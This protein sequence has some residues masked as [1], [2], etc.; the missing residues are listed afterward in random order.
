LA[1][2]GKSGK[3]GF[4]EK[5]AKIEKSGFLEI[6]KIRKKPENRQKPK[7]RDFGGFWKLAKNQKYPNGAEFEYKGKNVKVLDY[8]KS[9]SCYKIMYKDKE[10]LVSEKLLD[11]LT[12][13]KEENNES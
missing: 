9:Y 2:T 11:E 4:L 5:S 3:S 8:I 7:N 13:K 10:R 1:K 12:P 6:R